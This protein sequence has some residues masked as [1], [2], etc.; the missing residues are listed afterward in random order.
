MLSNV[1]TQT[2]S[3]PNC[4]FR[5]KAHKEANYP[6]SHSLSIGRKVE[7][8]G[9]AEKAEAGEIGGLDGK[10]KLKFSNYVMS[11]DVSRWKRWKRWKSHAITNG[12]VSIDIIYV[13][14]S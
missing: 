3:L 14:A 11:Y 1:P 5:P 10:K 4:T 13:D 6:G 9:T 8:D 12:D 2:N 7:K